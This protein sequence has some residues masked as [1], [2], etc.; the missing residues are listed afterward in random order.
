MKRKASIVIMEH[1]K[2]EHPDRYPWTQLGISE[3]RFY[4][5][6]PNFAEKVGGRYDYDQQEV[7]ASMGAHLA[8]LDREREIRS[9]AL[10]LLVS[11]GFTR[12]AARKWLQRHRVQD[13]VDAYP[14]GRAPVA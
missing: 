11:R 9:A 7:V 1:R 14:R 5:L 4:K 6:L 2:R 8:S 12:A 10:E 13:A 3:R